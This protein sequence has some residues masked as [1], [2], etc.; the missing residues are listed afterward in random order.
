M[1]SQSGIDKINRIDSFQYSLNLGP[2]LTKEPKLMQKRLN[3][4]EN[5]E[6]EFTKLSENLSILG[7]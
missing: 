1:P 4:H 7:F 6:P 5:Q 2:S 3:S